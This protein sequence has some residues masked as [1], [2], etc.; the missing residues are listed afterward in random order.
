MIRCEVVAVKCQP[1]H[2]CKDPK[3][4]HHHIMRFRWMC[5]LVPVIHKVRKRMRNVASVKHLK[6]VTSTYQ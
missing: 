6:P 3:P 1:Y 2:I 4:E 5:L